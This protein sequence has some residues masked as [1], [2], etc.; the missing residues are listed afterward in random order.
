M[1][2]TVSRPAPIPIDQQPLA[3][4]ESKHCGWCQSTTDFVFGHCG[5]CGLNADC[6]SRDDVRAAEKKQR[7]R[8]KV[9]ARMGT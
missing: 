3:T 5:H 6:L 9:R 7:E 8:E 4:G 1:T 2:K